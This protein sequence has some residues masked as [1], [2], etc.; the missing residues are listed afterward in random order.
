MKGC[1]GTSE[2]MRGMGEIE[3][4]GHRRGCNLNMWIQGRVLF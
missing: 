2:I 4:E 1:D 3:L